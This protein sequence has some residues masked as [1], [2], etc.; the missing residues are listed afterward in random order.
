MS[1]PWIFDKNRLLPWHNF[2]KK[3]TPHLQDAEE[4][5]SFY[6]YLLLNAAKK[7]DKQNHK[8]VV[9]ESYIKLLEYEGRVHPQDQCFICEGSIGEDVALMQAFK[10][11]H[12]SCI[13]TTSLQTNKF[14]KFIDMKS[15]IELE[16]YEVDYLYEVVMKGL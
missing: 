8:R 13:Y 4:V 2:I 9:C 10:V 15:T 5:E 11:S 1:F 6:F 3:F 16:D 7:W 12:P 14:L